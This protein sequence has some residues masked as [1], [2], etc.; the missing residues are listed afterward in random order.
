MPLDLPVDIWR[1]TGFLPDSLSFILLDGKEAEIFKYGTPF[2][3][4]AGVPS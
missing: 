1:S 3:D 2:T 4:R